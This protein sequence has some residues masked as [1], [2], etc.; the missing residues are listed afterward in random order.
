MDPNQLPPVINVP[1]QSVPTPTTE[2]IAPPPRSGGKL[3]LFILFFV[4]LFIFLTAMSGLAWAV[5][6]EKIQINNPTIERMAAQVVFSVPFVPKTPKYLLTAAVL[7]QQKITK[8]GFNISVSANDN[9]LASVFGLQQFDGEIKG[10]VD[11]SDKTNVKVTADLSLTKDFNMQLRKKDA[12]FYFKINKIPPIFLSYFGKNTDEMMKVFDN[13][14]S[15]DPATLNTEASKNLQEQKKSGSVEDSTKKISDIL[16]SDKILKAL[17]VG[18]ENVNNFPTYKIHLKADKELIDYLDK[19]IREKQVGTSDIMVGQAKLSDSVK[20]LVTDIWIDKQNYYIRKASLYIKT[21]TPNPS[22]L[23]RMLPQQS[24]SVLGAKIA[25]SQL[26]LSTPTSNQKETAVSVV[27]L[28]SDFDQ[29]ISVDV[30]EKALTIDE[31]YKLFISKSDSSQRIMGQTY[32]AVRKT[33]LSNLQAAI[34]QYKIEQGKY[35]EKLDDLTQYS[36]KDLQL[37]KV[38]TDPKSREPYKY[39]TNPLRNKYWL[40]AT[41]E[42][43][44]ECTVTEIVSSCPATGSNPLEATPSG[45][46]GY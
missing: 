8:Y 35:P 31:F 19:S 25:L 1:S 26:P 28:F 30:P 14:L 12:I 21:V 4:G 3:K 5:A 10:A 39:S 41:M 32:D 46:L 15:Y 44:T 9:S 43:G 42:D 33:D 17:E 37:H 22:N 23:E 34:G 45:S 16:L 7:A 13:W 6:S 38:P 18:E 40:K 20:D 29:P 24:S 11:Y 36:S 2:V 27:V